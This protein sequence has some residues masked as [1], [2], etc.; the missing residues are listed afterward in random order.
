MKTLFETSPRRVGNWRM[1]AMVA[2]SLAAET[3]VIWGVQAADEAIPIGQRREVFFDDLL[4]EKIDG[5]WLHLHPP[6][7][8]EI[9]FRFDQPWEGRYCGYITVLRD[10]EQFRMY[11]R[12][13]PRAHHGPETEVTCLAES[14]DGIHWTRPKLGLYQVAGTKENNVVLANNPACHNFAPFI[15]TRP[16]CPPDARYKAL[17]GGGPPGLLAFA[18][19]DGVRWRQLQEQPVFS[20]GAFDSQ[21]NAFWSEAEQRYVLYFRVFRHGVRWIARTTST[22]FLHWE[23]PVDL[24]V[25]NLPREHLYTNQ[26]VPYPRAPHIYVGFPT[27]FF[28][29]RRVVTDE[30][31]AEIGT[32]TEWPFANDCTDILLTAS[33][34][35]SQLFRWPEAYIRPGLDLRCWT[36]RANYAARGI[37]EVGQQLW[38]YVQHHCGYSSNHVRRYIIR[39]DGFVSVRARAG[40]GFL[41]TKPVV[42]SGRELRLNF[43]TSAGG[44]LRVELQTAEGKA[45]PGFSLD[46]CP[47]LIGD[48]LDHPVRWRGGG[49]LE[50]LA[51]QPVRLCFHLRDADLYALRFASGE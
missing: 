11:Y 28:P 51:G 20:D 48:R 44:S 19:P 47:E 23:K 37:I 21:N 33:R 3:G 18:S 2:I 38:L 42:F 43:S 13:M 49:T 5:C 41:L 24:E 17:G 50:K 6:Q 30:E 7:A 39:P 36:S 15:D 16:D 25:G 35:G 32:P 31:A 4:I 26:I 8:Q 14:S 46:D 1:V 29:G 34:G 9:V 10:G 22:D 45:I 40:G 12:G 27:R